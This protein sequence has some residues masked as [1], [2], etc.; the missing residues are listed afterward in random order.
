MGT[1]A[2]ATQSQEDAVGTIV[3]ATMQAFTAPTATAISAT[4]T[5]TRTSGTSVT[6][7]YASFV[8]PGE[9]ANGASP[10]LVPAV[11]AD[12][13]A[14]W[15]VAPA[16]LR[17]MLSGYTL[18]DKFHEPRILV[19]PAEEFA[20]AHEEAAEQ[21][22]RLRKALAGSPLLKET[23]PRIPFFNA[24]PL[25]AANIQLIPF[26][27]GRGV[28]VLTQYAQY[29]APINNRELFYHFQGLTNDEKY[30]VIAILPL[31]AAILPADEKPEAAIPE[32]GVTIP[33]NTGPTEVYYL[34]VTEK[35][36]SLAADAYLPSLEALDALIGSILVTTP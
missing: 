7:E 19:Y 35:L 9:V 21:I 11:G 34:S 31:T 16:H 28:R 12:G 22:D 13:G 26:Q 14:P 5:P 6:F 36:N 27:N 8:V 18:Q 4:D 15:E 23:L 24:G 2:V 3:A 20:Q 33:A 10:E 32:G 29:S 25:L 1:P 30:Y 17:F